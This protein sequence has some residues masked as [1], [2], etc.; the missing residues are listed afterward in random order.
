MVRGPVDDPSADYNANGD[1]TD[2][3][4]FPGEK[5]ARA[6][7]AGWEAVVLVN[8]HLDEDDSASIPFCGSGAYDPEKPM[9]TVCT[10]HAAAHELFGTPPQFAT[11]VPADDAPPLGTISVERVR[12]T[13]IFDGWGY[14]NLY[15]RGEGKVERIDSYAVP[16]A[17]DPDFAFGFGDLSI[18]EIATDPRRNLAYSSYYAAGVRVFRFGSFGIREVG[19]YIDEEGNNFWGVETFVPRSRAA[20]NL[21]GKR[22]F[23]GSDRDQ[24]RVATRSSNCRSR[25]PK[26]AGVF[27]S[28][29]ISPT[30][31][32][33]WKIGATI[34]LRVDGKQARY[35]SSVFTSSTTSV[36]PLAAAAPQTPWPTGIRTCSVA[37]GPFHGPSTRS[38]PS[39][40]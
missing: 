30:T 34:S 40:R 32:P 27:E 12:A 7:D 15:R 26:A 22:L 23:A 18:H 9:V 19:H 28:M 10:T 21:R 38:S 3:A 39:T 17:L 4:C 1:L 37:C 25:S 6:F 33:S 14:L 11:P 31:R 35:R 13:S 36:R 2:D 16:E 20:G 8:R 5:A 29:S 24:I